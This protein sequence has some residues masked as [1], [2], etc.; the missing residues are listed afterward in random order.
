MIDVAKELKKRKARR[1]FV[2]ATFGL[3]TNGL[4]IFDKYHEDGIIDRVLTSNVIYQTPELLNRSYYI[5]VDLSNILPCSLIPLIMTIQ[6]VNFLIHLTRLMLYLKD[7]ATAKKSDKD[8]K[9]Q[10]SGAYV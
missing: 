8:K 7:T 1:V 3:F 9:Q 4:A 5:S 10:P 6:S 2:A